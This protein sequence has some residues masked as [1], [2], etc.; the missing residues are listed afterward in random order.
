M[1]N[2]EFHQMLGRI[3]DSDQ[4]TQTDILRNSK[5]KRHEITEIANRENIELEQKDIEDL[6]NCIEELHKIK[7]SVLTRSPRN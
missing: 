5:D 6:V 4:T 7:S 3:L 1:G 2:K